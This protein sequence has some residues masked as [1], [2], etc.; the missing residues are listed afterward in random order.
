MGSRGG[1]EGNLCR[2][3]DRESDG[4][5]VERRREHI[6]QGRRHGDKK[7]QKQPTWGDI[8]TFCIVFALVVAVFCLLIIWRAKAF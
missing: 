1:Q 7:G 5:A 2:I 8:G 4:I 6:N 3:S